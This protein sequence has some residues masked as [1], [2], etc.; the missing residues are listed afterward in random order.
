MLL[1]FPVI[2]I[3]LSQCYLSKSD[4]IAGGI[5][6]HSASMW[7]NSFLFLLKPGKYWTVLQYMQDEVQLMNSRTHNVSEMNKRMTQFKGRMAIWQSSNICTYSSKDFKN[8]YW[9]LRFM[10]QDTLSKSRSQEDFPFF[11]HGSMWNDKVL[12]RECPAFV[13][14]LGIGYHHKRTPDEKI[15]CVSLGVAV[16][17]EGCPQ[18]HSRAGQAS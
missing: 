11:P 8:P 15:Q 16:L 7:N 5:P 17:T 4:W 12:H 9:L 6:K 2:W 1:S 10:S 3:E 14:C 13:S 18:K